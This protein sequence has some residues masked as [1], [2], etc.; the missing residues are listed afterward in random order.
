M[1]DSTSENKTGYRLNR[2]ESL[3]WLGLL[4]AFVALPKI[5]ACSQTLYP[6]S[7]NAG[8]WPNLKI[9]PITV[10]GLGKDPNLIVPPKT[11]WPR[12]LTQDQLVLVAV[13]SDWLVPREGEVPSASEVMVPDV[14]DEWVSA[15][16]PSQQNDRLDFLHGFAWIDDEA[17]FRFG[18]TFVQLKEVEQQ[19]ILDDIAFQNEN[20]PP[21]F[22]RIAEVFGRFRRL[23]L[24]AFFCSPEGTKD[25]GYVGNIAIA[26]DYPGPT[27]EA[28]E[29]LDQLLGDLE[30]S[31]D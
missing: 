11:P 4:S 10:P 21:Q 28:K 23:V 22:Q 5:T 14:I 29:H 18:N 6:A 2:R 13:L 27:K 3:R 31:L 16:Y 9:E 25:I 20:T 24:A 12:T 1:T 30:L 17:R 19:E 26:G 7:D 8:H 15:P